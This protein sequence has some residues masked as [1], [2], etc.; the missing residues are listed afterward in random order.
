MWL[1]QSPTCCSPAVDMH[2]FNKLHVDMHVFNKLH[3]RNAHTLLVGDGSKS[4]P[5]VTV[6]R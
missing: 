1:Q 3:V 2:V 5:G 6:K 4:T